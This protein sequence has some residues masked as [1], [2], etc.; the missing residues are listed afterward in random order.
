MQHFSDNL[1]L[2][3]KR[4]TRDG[5]LAVRAKAARAGIYD[6]L[7]SE[8]DPEGTRFAADQI[9]KV[10]RSPEEV[11]A[12]DSVASFL[13]K[14]VT[15]D[16]PAQPVTADNWKHYAKGI[17]GKAMRDGDFLAFDLVLMD[18]AII[19]EVESG[20]VE[21]S[22]GYASEIHF[23]DGV[24]PAGEA[25]QA[26]QT[27]I[28][29]NHVAVVDKGRAGGF[30]RI[31][32]SADCACIPT[33]EAA[34]IIRDGE[35]YSVEDSSV[36][37]SRDKISSVGEALMA[38]KQ[39]NFDGMPIE[40]TDQ[41][42]AAIRK[43]EGRLADASTKLATAETAVATL[44]TDKSTLEAKVVTLEAQVA[45]AKLTPAQLRDAARAYQVTADQAKA[46]GVTVTDEM[47]EAAMQRAAV[48]ARLGDAAK[49]WS[50]VQIAASFATLAKDAKP[51]SG[52]DPVR[53]IISD[54][55]LHRVTDTANIHAA[56]RA[57]RVR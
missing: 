41:A 23:R 28:R 43:L 10:Y 40:A 30:C 51:A 36:K 33:D 48:N 39:I 2:D 52:I 19:S 20:K 15:N 32:D 3:T 54:G 12:K 6:Y 8:V 47:D 57:A 27:T 42:E 50:D 21:L 45:D 34:Q 25:Y 31:T 29:G 4:R 22:N 37:N 11:F 53:K 7:G 14:P 56:A 49:D 16:H 35:T 44:T 55:A 24:T 5:Y 9:V 13:M 1:T 38:T 18:R 26:I 17:V 46:L